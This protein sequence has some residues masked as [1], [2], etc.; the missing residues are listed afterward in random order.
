MKVK[1]TQVEYTDVPLK[2]LRLQA[3][4]TLRELGRLSGVGFAYIN[5]IENGL[6]TTMDTWKRLKPH[7]TIQR[8][9]AQP[10]E[11]RTDIPQAAGS[12][13]AIPTN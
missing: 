12:N 6:P 3:G 13:P 11:Q 2:E 7:L 4:L 8:D 5:K 10:V 9:I 1:T